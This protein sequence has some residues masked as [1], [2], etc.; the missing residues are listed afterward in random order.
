MRA[1]FLLAAVFLSAPGFAAPETATTCYFGNVEY[2]VEGAPEHNSNALSLV[3]R[4]VN[5]ERGEITEVALEKDLREGAKGEEFPVKLTREGSSLSFRLDMRFVEG[6]LTFTNE[7]WSGWTYDLTMSLPHEEAVRKITGLGGIDA[8]GHLETVKMIEIVQGENVLA[9]I[10]RSESL[11]P[12]SQERYEQL[13]AE[14]L[15]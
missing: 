7:E 4:T 12:V 14:L 11:A 13:R 8:R 3:K 10:Q 6:V 5:R 9:R 1:I 15:K 2:T